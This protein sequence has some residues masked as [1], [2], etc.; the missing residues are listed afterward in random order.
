MSVIRI[1][2]AFVSCAFLALPIAAHAEAVAKGQ[3]EVAGRFSYADVDAGDVETKDT[4]LEL[5]YGRYL[6]DMHEVGVFVS[7]IDS[8]VE[9]YGDSESFDGYD[10]GLFYNLNFPMSGIITPYIGVDIATI[11]GDMGDVYDFSYG[12]SVGIK[13]YPYENAGVSFGVA[14]DKL[15]GAESYIDDADGWSLTAGLLM[16]F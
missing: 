3:N 14:Y 11:G 2:G 6:T 7:Y 8:E 4:T 13:I 10:L 1:V 15:N 16:R 9:V 12:A 5:A